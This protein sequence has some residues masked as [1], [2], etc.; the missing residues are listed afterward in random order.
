[1]RGHCLSV[2]EG[3]NF[4]QVEVILGVNCHVTQRIQQVWLALAAV[5][6]DLLSVKSYRAHKSESCFKGWLK[7]C[8]INDLESW[9][10]SSLLQRLVWHFPDTM[11]LEPSSC[12]YSN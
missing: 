1:M 4:L 3:E 6:T 10:Y 12:H 5:L 7:H 8:P 2:V 11:I 9:L